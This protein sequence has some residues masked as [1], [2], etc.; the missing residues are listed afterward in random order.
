MM[1]PERWREVERVYH[2]ARARDRHERSAFIRDAAGDEEIAREVES[3]L[4]CEDDSQSFLS[5]LAVDAIAA[6]SVSDDIPEPLIGHRLG[7][8]AIGSLI[9]FGGMGD[10][11]RARDTKLDRDVAI[12]ILPEMFAAD[13]GRRARFEREARVLA[14]LNHPNIAAIYG[15]EDSSQLHALVLELVD[16]HTLH[17][18]LQSGPMRAGEA[19]AVAGQIASALEA[20]H[21]TGVVHRDLKPRNI[22]LTAHGT[23][24]VLDFGLAKA[25]NDDSRPS[26]AQDADTRDGMLVGTTAYM[27][28]EQTRGES[29]GTETDVWAFGCVLMEML[30]GRR[31]F[32]GHTAPETISAILEREPPWQLIPAETPASVIRLVQRC[33]ERDPS[34]RVTITEARAVLDRAATRHSNPRRWLW[35]GAVAA[36]LI[37]VVGLEFLRTQKPATPTRLSLS[38]PG[39]ISPQLSATL[40]PDGRQIA[41]VATGDSGTLALWIRSLDAPEPRMIAGSENAAH[42]FWSPDGQAIGFLADG[43]VKTIHLAN[44]KVSTL[45]DTAERA[46]PSWSRTGQIL[47]VSRVGELAMIPA[48]GGAVT[49]VIAAPG[50]GRQAT[51]PYFLPDGRHFLFF[52]RSPKQDERGIYAGSLDSPKTTFI[53]QSEFKAAYAA[54]HLLFVREHELM[55]QP[56][57]LSTLTLSGAPVHIADGVWS[58][59]GAGQASFSASETGALAFV[60]G[61]VSQLQ[62]AWF[63]RNGRALEHV[64][65]AARYVGPPELSPDSTHALVSPGEAGREQIVSFD[66]ATDTNAVISR[67]APRTYPIW[68]RDGDRIAFKAPPGLGVMNTDGSGEDVIALSAQT[69]VLMDWSPDGRYLVYAAQGPRSLSDL[70]LLPLTGNR[71]PIPFAETA[72]NKTQAQLSPDGRWIAYT[73][74]ESGRDD[75]YIDRFPMAGAKQKISINGGAQPRWRR[76]G[77][78]LFYVAPDSRLVAVPVDAGTTFRSGTQQPLFKTRMIPH[79]SQSIGLSTMYDVSADGKRFLCFVPADESG[80]PISVILN[81]RF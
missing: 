65:N 2:A 69:I 81:W 64:G 58:A 21:A 72:Y 75:V 37:A 74:Y 19:I 9:G 57:D 51:F 14:S 22:A 68:S 18:R 11:Y 43:K 12:K 67:T 6:D 55:A 13:S 66:T 71:Q 30:I 5:G 60:N 54:G 17:E 16:G 40:S 28:P 8:Y 50:P 20:A 35:A 49:T 46:G 80:S 61:S 4:D 1:R 48:D 77:K 76:D 63:D 53:L 44:G 31:V 39:T 15:F 33:L 73:S 38:V 62:L 41:F 25:S 42:P 27:S 10:V 36:V 52:M 70:W 24:K 47:F 56:F 79:G 3:L 32:S 59:R 7:P 34:R 29:V 23:V 78:E 45:A 26:S